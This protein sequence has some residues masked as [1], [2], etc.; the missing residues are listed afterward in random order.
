MEV[1]RKWYRLLKSRINNCM[2][3]CFFGGGSL[4]PRSG[5]STGLRDPPLRGQLA[6]PAQ[7]FIQ[8]YSSNCFTLPLQNPRAPGW[9]S[10]VNFPNRIITARCNK[11][12]RHNIHRIIN[13]F[14]FL[15]RM[16][17]GYAPVMDV[18]A[19]CIIQIQNCC[20]TYQI[21]LFLVSKCLAGCH[22]HTSCFILSRVY[23]KTGESIGIFPVGSI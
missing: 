20:N 11:R 5:R 23:E 8:M 15:N 21:T 22:W 9:L 4:P 16:Q 2:L 12:N 1:R 19:F 18:Y 6:S 3:L 14:L 7:G 17:T 10:P 13:Q